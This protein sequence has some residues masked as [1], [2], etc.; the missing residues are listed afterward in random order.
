MPA[1]RTEFLLDAIIGQ[2]GFLRQFLGRNIRVD[3]TS[4]TSFSTSRLYVSES[5]TTL[6]FPVSLM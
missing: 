1:E 2:T 5:L 3:F 4:A 6:K